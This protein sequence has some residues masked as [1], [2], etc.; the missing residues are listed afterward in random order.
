MIDT[1]FLL[2]FLKFGV[3]GF[4]GVF[5]DFGIT[6]LLKE[7]LKVNKYVANSAGFICAVFSNYFLNRLWTFEDHNPD[8]VTQFMKFLLIAVCG[9]LINN[10]IIYLLTERKQR[11]NFYVAKL[12]ATLIV[13]FWNFGGNLLF[14]F[15]K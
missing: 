6:W 2:K 13:T 12:I 14:T 15:S 8:I 7:K 10:Y 9:L 4:S 3:V 5:V 1:S 11:A